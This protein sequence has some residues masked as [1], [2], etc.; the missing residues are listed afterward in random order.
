MNP[1][2][3]LQNKE[4]IIL[5]TSILNNLKKE[6]VIITPERIY[7]RIKFKKLSDTISYTNKSVQQSVYS[8]KLVKIKD[9]YYLSYHPN[10]DPLEVRCKINIYVNN[11]SQTLWMCNL[12][13]DID[14]NRY[15]VSNTLRDA[16]DSFIDYFIRINKNNTINKFSL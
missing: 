14:N 11:K 16:M 4:S 15:D 5:F 2:I 8:I 12:Y 13:I 3:K 9:K 7:Y 6:D 10:S 1:I